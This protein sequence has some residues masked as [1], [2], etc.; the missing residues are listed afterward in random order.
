MEEFPDLDFYDVQTPSNRAHLN[1]KSA[2]FYLYLYLFIFIS[3]LLYFLPSLVQAVLFV[4]LVLCKSDFRCDI[5]LHASREELR[6]LCTPLKLKKQICRFQNPCE[7]SDTG[8]HF[9]N[10]KQ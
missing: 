10:L 4:R 5:M 9:K 8:S 3:Y 7:S 6:G 2:L 1:N